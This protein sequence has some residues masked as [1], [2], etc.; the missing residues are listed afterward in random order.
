MAN[1]QWIAL[2][3]AA[4][5]EGCV[6]LVARDYVADMS[7][8]DKARLPSDCRPGHML[9]GDDVAAYAY[10]LTRL[11]CGTFAEELDELDELLQRMTAF[12]AHASRRLVALTTPPVLSGEVHRIFLHSFIQGQAREG[13][14]KPRAL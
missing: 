1:A 5:S 11:H 3:D 6:V 4:R 2:L 7:E 12:F 10:T 14:G 8:A 9:D 13:D